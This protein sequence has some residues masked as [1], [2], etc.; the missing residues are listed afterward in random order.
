M[1]GA[2]D[3]F[4]DSDSDFQREV[5]ILFNRTSEVQVVDTNVLGLL[6]NSVNTT[7]SLL[8]AHWVPRKIVVHQCRELLEVKAFRGRVRPKQD[9]NK[10]VV[11]ML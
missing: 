1:Q 11:L 2:N 3:L 5:G 6:T 8:D 4:K 7:D 10:A 9:V